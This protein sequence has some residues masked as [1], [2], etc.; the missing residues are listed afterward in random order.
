MAVD[1]DRAHRQHQQHRNGQVRR[2]A[3]G[4]WW[5]KIDTTGPHGMI[6]KGDEGTS[7]PR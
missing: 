7:T 2:T 5:W 6:A 3:S 4:V 1:A